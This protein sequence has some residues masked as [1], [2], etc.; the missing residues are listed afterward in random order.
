MLRGEVKV[1]VVIL[2][3]V[4]VLICFGDFYF[5]KANNIKFSLGIA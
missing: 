5:C 2:V 3:E 1:C 4:K